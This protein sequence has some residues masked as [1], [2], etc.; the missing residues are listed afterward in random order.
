MGTEGLMGPLE[1]V[2]ADS[3]T[4]TNAPFLFDV[5]MKT[6]TRTALMMLRIKADA[7]MARLWETGRHLKN[8]I[9]AW[10]NAV[11]AH[12]PYYSYELVLWLLEHIWSLEES[13]NLPAV[14]DSS[15]DQWQN[16]LDKVD[17]RLHRLSDV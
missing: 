12:S 11:D 17:Q 16:F 9:G 14:E 5:S 7:H 8:D 6:D 2:E 3:D 1:K 13:F 10:A 4:E 15:Y